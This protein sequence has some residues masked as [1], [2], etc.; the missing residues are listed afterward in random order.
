MLKNDTAYR[1]GDKIR[2]IRERKG[3]TMKQVAE[4]ACVS[5]S[6][7]SQIERNR[8]SPSIDTLLTIADIL[9]IDLHYLFSDYQRKRNVDLVRSNEQGR[10]DFGGVTYSRL[11]AINRYNEEHG[12]EAF[13]LEIGPS[14]EKGSSEYGHPGRELGY[15]LEGTGQL[16][17]G[18]E[19]YHLCKGDSISF[20]SDIPHILQNT[21]SEVLRALWVITPPR[22]LFSRG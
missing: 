11:S 10:F 4:K 15:I 16:I 9:S 8:V 17:Y 1:F 18:S 12:L 21:G 19:T 7:I 13:L 22:M 3:L 6:L 2:T 14:R 5:E 20:T